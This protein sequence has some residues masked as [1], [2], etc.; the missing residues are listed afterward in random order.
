MHAKVSLL[1]RRHGHRK[2]WRIICSVRVTWRMDN[3]KVEDNENLPLLML[4]TY[5]KHNQELD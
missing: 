5:K 2:W 3:G 1:Q 4:G